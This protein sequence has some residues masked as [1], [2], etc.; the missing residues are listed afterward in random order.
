MY[1]IIYVSMGYKF[2]LFTTLMFK[3]LIFFFKFHYFLF[4]LWI[5]I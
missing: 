5:N 2:V 4:M 1:N 3:F